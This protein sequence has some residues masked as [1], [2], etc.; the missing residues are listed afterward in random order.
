MLKYNCT[1]FISLWHLP[2][3]DVYPI[4]HIF[5]TS[6]PKTICL[7]IILKQILAYH[8]HVTILTLTSWGWAVPSSSQAGVELVCLPTF[9]FWYFSWQPR[10][11][12]SGNWKCPGPSNP[13]KCPELDKKWKNIQSWAINSAVPKS[14]NFPI[15]L[16]RGIVFGG[17]AIT[18]NWESSCM[19]PNVLFSEISLSFHQ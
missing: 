12:V 18:A 2:S 5:H 4:Q 15:I 10:V 16:Y 1:I 6:H 14:H 17:G 3:V 9:V 11:L 13:L 8:N 19:L 7:I